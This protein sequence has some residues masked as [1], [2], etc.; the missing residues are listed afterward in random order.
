MF[1]NEKYANK[2]RMIGCI[3]RDRFS[4]EALHVGPWVTLVDKSTV[5]VKIML[6]VNS[7]LSGSGGW[8]VQ[9]RRLHMMST[10][11]W[12]GIFAVP[13]PENPLICHSCLRRTRIPAK[14][15]S[16][17]AAGMRHTWNDT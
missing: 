12:T 5:S 15:P 16:E 17:P 10:V 6:D 11:N 3:V 14:G 7:S 1:R 2:I 8:N 9:D 4:K 13:R